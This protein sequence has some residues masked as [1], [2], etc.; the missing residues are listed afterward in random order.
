MNDSVLSE[1]VDLSVGCPSHD[2]LKHVVSMVNP[3]FL[4]ELKLSFE[5][6]SE[7]ADFLKLIAIDGKTIRG[8][9][10]KHQLPTH[11]VIAYDGGNR[12][13]IGQVAIE[14]VSAE[15]TAIPR[16]LRQ[17]DLRKSIV[18]IDVMGT[19]TDIAV[20]IRPLKRPEVR[21]R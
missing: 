8:N 19:Q 7:R 4:K 17:I 5:S 13:S 18:T 6:T 1:Y 2:T 16:L 20:I 15:I 10:G 21:L 12:I 9:R 3:D 11:I 14:D